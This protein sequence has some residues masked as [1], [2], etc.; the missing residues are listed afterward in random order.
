[1]VL[2]IKNLVINAQNSGTLGRLILGLLV[3]SPEPI[4]LIGDK[5]LTKRDFRRVSDPSANLELNLN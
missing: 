4:N 3:N 1:M 2:N 5:S